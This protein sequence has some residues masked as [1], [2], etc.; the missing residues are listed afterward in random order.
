MFTSQVKHVA[1]M[2]LALFAISAMPPA[3]ASAAGA[4]TVIAPDLNNSFYRKAHSPR[5]DIRIETVK[6]LRGIQPDL[7]TMAERRK[8][9]E[10]AHLALLAEP[11]A[12]FV[13][14]SFESMLASDVPSSQPIRVELGIEILDVHYHKKFLGW[15]AGENGDAC[16]EGRFRVTAFTD[17]GR[18]EAGWLQTEHVVPVQFW[19]VTNAISKSLYRGLATLA[20][21]LAQNEVR[22]PSAGGAGMASGG[23]AGADAGGAT[24]APPATRKTAEVEWGALRATQT[25]TWRLA[26]IALMLHRA[27]TPSM[28]DTYGSLYSARVSVLSIPDRGWVGWYSDPGFMYGSGTPAARP[29]TPIDPSA[30]I[31]V[32]E[33]FGSGGLIV[34][35]LPGRTPP[36]WRPFVRVGAGLGGGWQKTKVSVPP[37]EVALLGLGERVKTS[38]IIVYLEAHAGLGTAVQ[39]ARN[40]FGLLEVRWTQ[41]DGSD[42]PSET[43]ITDLEKAR[44]SYV[45]GRL[46]RPNNDITSLGMYA[47]IMGRW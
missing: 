8:K 28:K 11:A 12:D 22:L 5:P 2:L 36:R 26:G 33:F 46:D 47:G 4:R 14:R 34:R 27:T 17:S 6:D 13:K 31:S 29:G 39:V 44:A 24:G 42:G 20:L 21:G 1:G 37:A 9:P 23:E 16:F 38:A 41:S 18:V 3:S 43:P 40:T 25:N 32:S 30:S 15:M 7:L 10:K 35:L 19:S 45:E